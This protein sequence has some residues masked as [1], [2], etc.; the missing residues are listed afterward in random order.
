M[1]FGVNIV[2]HGWV[3]EPEHFR[4][5]ARFPEWAGLHAAL[6]SDHVAVTP[7]VAEP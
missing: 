7:D 6:V 2:N 4:G 3:A 5:W 1:K